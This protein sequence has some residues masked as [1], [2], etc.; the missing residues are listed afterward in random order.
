MLN[1]KA[2]LFFVAVLPQFL[3]P[4]GPVAVQIDGLGLLDV[5]LGAA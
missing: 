1:L 2:A 4:G 3:D 5:A